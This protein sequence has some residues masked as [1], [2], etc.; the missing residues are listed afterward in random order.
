VWRDEIARLLDVVG[1]FWSRD[2][3]EFL[4]YADDVID[5]ELYT[6]LPGLEAKPTLLLNRRSVTTE[7]LPALLAS[8]IAALISG[9]MESAH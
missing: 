3:A 5:A 8:I 2:V 1:V 4:W 7:T 6:R 9:G